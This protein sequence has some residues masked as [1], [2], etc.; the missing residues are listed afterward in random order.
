MCCPGV[1]APPRSG[2]RKRCVLSRGRRPS[3]TQ[4]PVSAARCLGVA[5]ALPRSGSRKRCALSRGRRPSRTQAPVS[6]VIRCLGVAAPPALRLLMETRKLFLSSGVTV[7]P[8]CPAQPAIAHQVNWLLRDQ[9]I[10]EAL[11]GLLTTL[12]HSG[13]RKR[14]ALS[15]DRRPSR[16]QVPASAARCLGVAAPP[17]LRFP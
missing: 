7:L 3:R 9:E 6:A 14:R 1:A 17:A 4:A 8:V 15:R 16:A 5:N 10:I 13:S 2:S 11:K 12:P